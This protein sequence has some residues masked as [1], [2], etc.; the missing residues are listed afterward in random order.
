MDAKTNPNDQYASD[1]LNGH[2]TNADDS[3][4]SGDGSFL[5][6]FSAVSTTSPMV[7]AQ[8]W[9][10]DRFP[11]DLTAGMVL[12][13]SQ[14]HTGW[15]HAATIGKGPVEKR[16]NPSLGQFARNPGPGWRRIFTVPV[17]ILH[18]DGGEPSYA[19]WADGSRANWQAFDTLMRENFTTF[20]AQ[21]PLL[22][23]VVVAEIKPLIIGREVASYIPVLA[24][25]EYV[26]A[27]R[28]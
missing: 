1:N 28:A 13:P 14:A 18:A 21:L 24:V 15:E 6:W 26:P 23:R 9:A 17:A 19:A 11:I 25:A 8:T 3:Y 20:R 22:P 10:V 2:A 12:D 7:P 4:S 16:W 5:R 27:R